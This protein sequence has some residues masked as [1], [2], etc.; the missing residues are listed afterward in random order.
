[1]L[2]FI[3]LY[4]YV[5]GIGFANTNMVKR[6]RIFNYFPRNSFTTSNESLYHTPKIPVH[7]ACDSICPSTWLNKSSNQTISQDLTGKN[8]YKVIHPF[9]PDP[10]NKSH[11]RQEYICMLT[12]DRKTHIT[13]T[14]SA[15]FGIFILPYGELFM[16]IHNIT[17]LEL[18]ADHF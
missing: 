4:I 10:K 11:L 15:V 6:P 14:T 9:E 16:Y 2:T 17:R 7:V 8:G 13:N 5:G 12:D 1:M 3:I 18:Y